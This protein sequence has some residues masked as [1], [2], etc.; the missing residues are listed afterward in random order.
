MNQNTQRCATS[1]REKN[2][3]LPISFIWLRWISQ[4]SLFLLIV[5]RIH[6]YT[7]TG[8]SINS[9]L[10]ECLTH[11]T[12]QVQFPSENSCMSPCRYLMLFYSNLYLFIT[13]NWYRSTLW[14]VIR[15]QYNYMYLHIPHFTLL[16]HWNCQRCLFLVWPLKT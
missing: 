3:F 16:S 11:I 6:A 5:D 10:I 12:Y 9:F 15:H 14:M 4:F 13:E 7:L 1:E 2:W 8:I